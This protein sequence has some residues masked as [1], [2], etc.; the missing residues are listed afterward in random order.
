MPHIKSIALWSFGVIFLGAIAIVAFLTIAG[1]DFYRW[2]MRQAIEGTIDREIRAEGSFSFSV[3]LE[4]SVTVT[5]V[6]LENAP[7]ANTKE[8]ARAERVEVQ[9]A[10]LP[11]FSGIVH[12]PQLVVEGLD[13]A[14]ERS[15]DGRGNWV[16][17]GARPDEREEAIDE[18]VTLPLFGFV[19]L[20][21]VAVTYRDYQ[22]G[23]DMEFLLDFLDKRQDADEASLDI[24]AEGSLNGRPFQIGRPTHWS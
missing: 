3:G 17:G 20:K 7:W 22:D 19:S 13:V 6:W 21:D 14:L 15:S 2:M 16:F 9:I 8:M 5:D 4:P 18:D 1:D 11:L 12:V 24:E 10:L 23:R